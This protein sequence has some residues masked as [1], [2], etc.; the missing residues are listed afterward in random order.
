MR[1]ALYA[2]VAIWLLPLVAY[3]QQQYQ[4]QLIPA[5]HD[6][7]AKIAPADQE[8]GELRT[9]P[10]RQLDRSRYTS[11]MANIEERMP[12]QHVYRV[13]NDLS[14]SA[15]ETIHGINSR[16]RNEIGAGVGAFYMGK[17]R[18]WIFRTPKTTLSRVAARTPN[19]VR[20][21]RTYP[22]YMQG[23]MQ[24]AW[25]H[26]PLYILDEWVAYLGGTEASLEAFGPVKD[27]PDTGT[28]VSADV[29]SA[30]FLSAYAM[31][32]LYSIEQDDPQYQD[33]DKL[34]QF[35]ALNT[36]RTMNL[37][38]VYPQQAMSHIQ[39]TFYQRYYNCQ[40]GVCETPTYRQQPQQQQTWRAVDPTQQPLAAIPPKP[41]PDPALTQLGDVINKN[42]KALEQ[43]IAETN[44]Q[45]LALQQQLI[46]NVPQGPRGE[47]GPTGERGPTGLNGKDGKD[48]VSPAVDTVVAETVKQLREMPIT[49]QNIVDGKVV[50]KPVVAYLGESVGFNFREE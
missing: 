20:N 29:E 17:D 23:Q 37:S 50:G 46:L 9:L 25:D 30:M 16:L 36:Q 44:K 21:N 40:D 28:L 12:E 19:N 49:F 2:I 43:H 8:T 7:P 1:P 34:K 24:E 35:I 14:T 42:A 3:G 26:E 6:R 13:A 22:L 47:A 15:H 5:Y 39:Q 4:Q 27:T 32:L 38:K 10:I 41:K 31:V 48:G 33:M 18:V 11:W 45:I